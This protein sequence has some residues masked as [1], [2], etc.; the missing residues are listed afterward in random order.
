MAILSCSLENAQ[1]DYRFPMEIQKQ[2]ANISDISKAS[3]G[4]KEIINLAFMLAIMAHLDLKDYPLFL[5]EIG[6]AFDQTHQ[7]KSADF[8]KWL[9]ETNQCSQI[10][11]ATHSAID[12][13]GLKDSQIC[14]LNANN[15]SV[16]QVYNQHVSIS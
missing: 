9:I 6:S 7:S 15:I 5:D 2:S 4:Q 16:P 12:H 14:V 1:L 3:D 13:G 10:W 11:L 8:I